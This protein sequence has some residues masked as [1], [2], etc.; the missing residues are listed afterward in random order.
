M[1]SDFRHALRSLANAPGF[2]AVAIG[3]LALGIGF[4][5]AVFSVV[6][7]VLLRPL[8]YARPAELVRIFDRNPSKE[9]GRFSVSPRNF[10]D[11]REQNAT[12]S[13]MAAFSGDDATL[14]EG[15]EPERLRAEE[16]SPALFPVLGVPPLLGRTFDPGDEKPGGASVAVLSWSLWQRRFGGDP[17]IVGRTLRFEDARRLVVGVM[18]RDFRFPS[19]SADLWFPLVLTEQNLANRGQH[20]LGALG[21]LKPGVPVAAAQADF[22]AIGARLAA[23]YPEKNSGWRQEIVPL[24]EAV[25]GDSRKPLRL[26]VVAVA[27]VLL[28]ACVNVSNLLL[29]RGLARRREVAIR[30]AI[31]ASRGRIVR[32]F[33]AETFVLALSGGALGTVGAVWL[34]AALV[35]LGGDALPRSAEISVD[36]RSLL[37]ALA[38]GLVAAALAGLLPALS[39]SGSIDCEALRESPGRATSGRRAA[40]LRRALLSAQLALAL[41]LLVG[42][43]L[44]LRS[45][46]AALSVDPGFRP[47]GALVAELSLPESRYPGDERALAF[48]EALMARLRRLP[49]VSAVGT[50]IVAPMPGGI[51]QS[52]S[53]KIPDHPRPESEEISLLYR[54][55]GG[56]FFAA[57]GIPL[58]RGRVFSAVDR[59]GAPLVAVISETAARRCFP[60]EDPIGRLINPGDRT[61]AP[62]RIIGVVGDV[63]EESPTS[64]PDANIYIPLA[65][66]PWSEAAVIIRTKGDPEA[67]APEVR[68][69]IRALDPELPLDTLAPLSEQVG[70]ALA[71]RRFLLTLLALFA[72]LALTIATIGMYGVASRSAA[73]RRREIGIRVA[74]GAGSG[75]V[76]GLF[77]GEGARTAAIGWLAGLLLTLPAARLTAGLLFGVSAADPQSFTAVS[78]VLA[79]A[80]VLANLVPAIRALRADP[81]AALRAD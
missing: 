16:V 61:P 21:R 77:V 45:M 28:L 70:R 34:T 8:A 7:A 42:A 74:L 12:L 26:L 25:S 43:A 56:D 80:T 59:Q 22:D 27:F 18:P 75:D 32:Q 30:T 41:V 53:V 58:R 3:T 81:V 17:A 2:A 11:W 63:R 4:N 66:K 79:A 35:R 65:Q 31:G 78:L 55:V 19:R 13:G 36:A 47:D 5:T 44:L 23:A 15:R 10:A 67:I 38:A 71:E 46:R 72:I 29:A 37:F 1:L 48:Y 52:Y 62:R 76:L 64:P 49:S 20:W 40:T 50:S 24:S 73:E 9:I 69:Q 33:L 51:W 39:A 54:V 14:L 60:G 6:D 68:E 57:A